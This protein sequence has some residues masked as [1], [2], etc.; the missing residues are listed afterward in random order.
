MVPFRRNNDMSSTRPKS[1]ATRAWW[2]GLS[3]LSLL[4]LV[5]PAAA[6]DDLFAPANQKS[7]P[8]KQTPAT[9]KGKPTPFDE[10]IDF[11]ITVTPQEGRRGETVQLTITGTPRPGFHT[12]PLTQRSA[13]REAQDPGQLSQLKY[14]EVAGL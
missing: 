7:E 4:W 11:A 14:G 9:A 6:Q 12:Y 3:L 10:R 5:N 13:D 2:V 8:A 1:F